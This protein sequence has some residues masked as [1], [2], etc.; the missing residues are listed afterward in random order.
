VTSEGELQAG[1]HGLAAPVLA[2]VGVEASVGVVALGDLDAARVGP[3]V[4]AAARE[5]ARR[6]R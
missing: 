4:A 2:D 5:V 3:K 6:L 1:A